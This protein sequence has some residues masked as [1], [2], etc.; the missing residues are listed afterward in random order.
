MPIE[1]LAALVLLAAIALLAIGHR[2]A[3]VDHEPPTLDT[4]NHL[5]E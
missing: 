4:R 2:E 5:D 1:A 3:G